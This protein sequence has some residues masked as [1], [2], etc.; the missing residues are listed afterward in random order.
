MFISFLYML[1]ATMCPSSGETAVSM[2]HFIFVT[3]CVDDCLVYKV[4]FHPT[5]QTVIHTE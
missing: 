4:E 1:Q 3:M 2:Q 5:Y